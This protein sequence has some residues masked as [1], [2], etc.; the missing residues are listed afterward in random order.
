MAEVGFTSK[1]PTVGTTIFSKMSALAKENKIKDNIKKIK[2]KFM[3][4][5]LGLFFYI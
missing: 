5:K 3:Y 1:L 2:K 4:F